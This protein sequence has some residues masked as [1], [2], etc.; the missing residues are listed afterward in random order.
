MNTLFRNTL[1]WAAILLVCLLSYGN[2]LQ[3][4]L[5][6][7]D[8]YIF[9]YLP[10]PGESV[11]SVFSQPFGYADYRPLSLLS[12]ALEQ[13][14]TGTIDPHTAHGVNLL[15]FT[16]LCM[17]IYATIR[18]LPFGNAGLIALCATLLFAAHPVHSGVVSSIKSRDTILS[19]LMA[20]GSV[21]C[22]IRA[23]TEQRPRYFIPAFLL[24]LA[25]LYTK[26]D[27][28]VL[29]FIIPLIQH[30]FFRASW[31]RTAVFYFILLAGVLFLRYLPV[32]RLILDDQVL[33]Q[34]VNFAENPLSAQ[35][36]FANS[37]SQAIQTLFVY[38]KFMVIP[39]GYYFYFGYDTLPLHELFSWQTL[40]FL[41][42]QLGL[43]G[44]AV[45][46][47]KR[48]PVLS[49][50]VLFFYFSL[51]YCSNLIT[52]V[53]GIV[54]DRYAF[55]ASLGFCLFLAA[56]IYALAVQLMPREAVTAKAKST[57]HRD[58]KDFRLNART[59]TLAAT[60]ILTL[61]YTGFTANRNR[62]WQNILTLL[63]AD[64]PAL[65]RSFEANRIAA[66]NYLKAA[67]ETPDRDAAN[68]YTEKGL[69]CALAARSVYPNNAFIFESIGQAYFN[70]GR[71]QEAIP[72][73]QEAVQRF[74]TLSN[75][76]EV[77]GDIYYVG[78]KQYDSAAYYYRM[79]LYRHTPRDLVALKYLRALVQLD[80][81]PAADRYS[82]SLLLQRPE[83]YFAYQCKAF[84]LLQRN[85]S[86]N[87]LRLY[88]RSFELGYRNPQD[89]RD[90]QQKLFRMK[91][92]ISA[93]KL[94]A[95]LQP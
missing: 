31:K 14:L 21:W 52:P 9:N 59:V 28:M 80:D 10:F 36:G 30:I 45:Y 79:A 86:I 70:L 3:H 60:I 20:M 24:F 5:N 57:R 33:R 12:F 15:L 53:A 6:L 90:V 58:P 35:P 2:I 76:P 11:W 82:D 16:G 61:I 73:L 27:S 78:G 64:I 55:Y 81:L 54:A 29:V 40:L 13:R 17:L 26:L 91:D 95:Y 92:T 83:N 56:G 47:Y 44:F 50:A 48:R 42:P 66:S 34:S 72:V 43:A 88:A 87:G 65:G 7:D 4:D 51:S 68:R 89:A 22:V 23:E 49:F 32:N 25:G 19:L 38:L 41:L 63:D 75:S 93:L 74:D 62:D 8:A 71:P 37:L 85:D 69:Q 94:N 18:A 67:S 1:P 77:L 46:Q 39:S 84:V